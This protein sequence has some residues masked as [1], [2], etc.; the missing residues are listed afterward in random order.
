MD[1]KRGFGEHIVHLNIRR[2]YRLLDLCR[3]FQAEIVAAFMSN[4]KKNSNIMFT[5]ALLLSQYSVNCRSGL[6]GS[7]LAY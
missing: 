4:S 1:F 7:V 3:V 2:S 5:Y 6:V